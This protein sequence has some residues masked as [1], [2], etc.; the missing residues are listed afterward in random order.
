[1]SG[2]SA[3]ASETGAPSSETTEGVSSIGTTPLAASPNADDGAPAADTGPPAPT[4]VADTTAPT[5]TTPKATTRL[6]FMSQLLPGACGGGNDTSR[7]R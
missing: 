7:E 1:M 4:S 3:S 6:V 5:I 2:T